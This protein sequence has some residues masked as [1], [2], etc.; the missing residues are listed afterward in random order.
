MADTKYVARIP[1]VPDDFENQNSHKDHELV[2]DFEQDDLYVKKGDGYVNI[3]GQIKEDVKDVTD[4]S[5]VIH[6]VTEQTVPPIDNRPTN[7]W[8][9]IITRSKEQSGEPVYVNKYIYYGLIKNPYGEN[10]NLLI[11]QN[12]T[13]ESDIIPFTILEGY[14]PC[15]YIPINYTASFTFTGT[16][17]T[18]DYEIKDRIYAIN[19]LYGTYEA[20]DV[21]VL[22]ITDPG[23]YSV[24][25]TI[26]GTDTFTVTFGANIETIEGL[27][28]PD[29]IEVHLGQV[30]GFVQEPIKEDPHYDFQ[31][32]STSKHAYVPVNPEVYQP[33]ENVT[34]YA[35][36]EYN[37]GT[38]E[39]PYSY[40]QDST[41]TVTINT[42]PYYYEEYNGLTFFDYLNIEVDTEL[43]IILSL[44]PG[45]PIGN[46]V[47][48]WHSNGEPRETNF[49]ITDIRYVLAT[50]YNDPDSVID[51]TYVP[52]EDTN[53][54]VIFDYDK[55]YL[56]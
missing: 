32:W 45:E 56:T 31:G 26:N 19:T 49:G 53:I 5:S 44:T 40:E 52:T 41:V 1:V 4:G 42:N 47:I 23:E 36:Y 3:T 24:T 14:S 11:G 28:L 7:H 16:I 15:F 33:E 51:E 34:L 12:V 55:F 21:Y 54:Y 10:N 27:I 25:L 9:Y 22:D 6:I 18:I 35:W 48:D 20:Y 39:I 17:D 30:I 8:Y 38:G 43:P 29:P 50:D 13:T 37:E 46:V 2:M